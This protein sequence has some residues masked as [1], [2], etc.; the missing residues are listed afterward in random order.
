MDFPGDAEVPPP[1]AAV[2]TAADLVQDFLSGNSAAD[3][4][5]LSGHYTA[6]TAAGDAS[7]A[8]FLA[9]RPAAAAAAS[10]P[11]ESGTGA[12]DPNSNSNIGGVAAD[13][14]SQGGAEAP[15]SADE[16]LTGGEVEAGESMCAGLQGNPSE[17]LRSGGARGYL[18][19]MQVRA[20][21]TPYLEKHVCVRPAK[22][23][24][25]I[26]GR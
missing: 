7:A 9:P 20:D 17:W 24:P 19:A 6:A 4:S 18:C 5:F 1:A 26:T 23:P 12:P 3:H 11:A 25:S 16:S 2:A 8:A 13:G 10:A 22:F 15:G 14:W 21:W